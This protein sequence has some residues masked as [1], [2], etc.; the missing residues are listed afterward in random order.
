MAGDNALLTHDTFDPPSCDH[1]AD[2]D[3]RDVALAHI[4]PEDI[5]RIRAGD[6]A[7]LDCLLGEFGHL[8]LENDQL[9]A[10]LQHARLAR[11]IAHEAKKQLDASLHWMEEWR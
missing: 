9:Q 8:L 2:R 3:P 1:H 6:E 11:G 7:A 4:P 5:D 10:R